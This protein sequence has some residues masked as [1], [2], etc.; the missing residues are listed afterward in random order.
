MGL[1]LVVL[2]AL[3][4]ASCAAV[5]F[6]TRQRATREVPAERGMSTEIVVTSSRNPLWWAGAMSAVTGYGFQALALAKGSL[7]LVQPLL[8]TSLLF[9]LLISAAVS[10]RRIARS[11][12][13]WAAVLTVGLAAFVLLGKPREGHERPPL[14][15]WALVLAIFVPLVAACVLFAA[16]WSGRRRAVLLAIAVA[17]LL[18]MV[19]ALTKISV[20]RLG[21][22]GLTAMLSIPAPYLVPI[23]ALLATV[24]QQSAF[25]AGELQNSIPTMLV[26]EP[27]VAVLL[28]VVVLGE[29]LVV[30]GLAAVALPVAIV[31]TVGAIIALARASAAYEESLAARAH[32]PESHA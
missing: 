29:H 32:V 21:A 4:A 17:M 31:A 19:A 11:E 26:L 5:G 2:L 8:A 10:H 18:P 30:G 28:G 12:W 3:L 6:V 13:A 22:D 23:L 25:H 16:R 1:L 24:L 20:H 14:A 7:L 15:A 9:A 27:L